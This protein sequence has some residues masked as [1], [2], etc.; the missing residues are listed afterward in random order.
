MLLTNCKGNRLEVGALH[1]PVSEGGVFVRGQGSSRWLVVP[2]QTLT[3]PGFARH[4]WPAM[5]NA[6]VS[7][8]TNDGVEPILQSSFWGLFIRC[9]CP[10]GA[11]DGSKASRWPLITALSSQPESRL[12]N[13]PGGGRTT[14]G[15]HDAA[16]PRLKGLLP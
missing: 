10:H 14:A 12:S 8:H 5:G 13:R 7:M 2:V 15:L 16:A 6:Q 1:Q 9:D 3:L 11:C 4:W